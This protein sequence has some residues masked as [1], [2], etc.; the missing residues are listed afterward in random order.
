LHWNKP[1]DTGN[2]K[3][4]GYIVE[5]KPSGGD[6]KVVNAYLLREPEMVVH[7]LKEGQ[8]YQFRV[9]AVNEAGSGPPST[10]TGPVVAK[11][12]TGWYCDNSTV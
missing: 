10:A 8:Q 5:M 7:D 4:Q 12:P 6:W 9:T 2:D 11:K 1:S 3:L